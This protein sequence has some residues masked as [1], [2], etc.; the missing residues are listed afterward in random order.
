MSLLA[1]LLN[2]MPP[3]VAGAGKPPIAKRAPGRP[4]LVL[5][6][7]A[8]LPSRP[9][10]NAANATPE[11]RQAGVRTSMVRTSPR[12]RRRSQRSFGK[13]HQSANALVPR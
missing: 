8:P 1:D 10:A 2:H 9:Y 13:Q 12:K 7:P 3:N 11:W 6:E 5:V 4:R